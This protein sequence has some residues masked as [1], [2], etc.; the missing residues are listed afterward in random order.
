M[1]Q[2]V[3]QSMTQLG[4]Q[5][6]SNLAQ[7]RSPYPSCPYPSEPLPAS[8]SHGTSSVAVGG[9]KADV[10]QPSCPTSL[11]TPSLAV[12]DSKADVPRPTQETESIHPT[13]QATVSRKKKSPFAL[14]RRED[15]YLLRLCLSN[16]NHT[17]Y[18]STRRRGGTILQ[19]NSTDG[20]LRDSL[21][22]RV[23][24]LVA[25]RK[26][27]IDMLGSEDEDEKRPYI[28]AIDKWIAINTKVEKR[29][30]RALRA[31]AKRDERASTLLHREQ[32]NSKDLG[33]VASV[34]SS[35]DEGRV[36][37]E[38]DHVGQDNAIG[39]DTSAPSPA[40]STPE[41][42]GIEQLHQRRE[43]QARSPSITESSKPSSPSLSSSSRGRRMT[44]AKRMRL[45]ASVS[46]SAVD[47]LT[48]ALTEL[49]RSWVQRGSQKGEEIAARIKLLEEKAENACREG[50]TARLE[51]ET[52]RREQELANQKLDKLISFLEPK[53]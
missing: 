28:E 9:P 17:L 18:R 32:Q 33:K 38:L 31:L 2:P 1:H 53:R 14:N 46:T 34:G 37:S 19:R 3:P 12:E 21:G 10:P 25:E 42:R 13:S 47:N 52:A 39:L 4:F 11:G 7:Y 41:P 8:V 49:N 24:T 20:A 15:L 26:L 22:R 30:L 6:P 16:R 43:K 36:G 44:P 35:G 51:R 23:K 50:E 5:Q 27:Q 40:L 45:E 29:H 48:R